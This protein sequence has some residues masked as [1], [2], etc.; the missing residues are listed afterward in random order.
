MKRSF[1]LYLFILAVLINVFTYAFFTR[2]HEAYEKE[3]TAKFKKANDSIIVLYNK[4]VDAEYFSI[5]G[6]QNAQDYLQ[7]DINQLVQVITNEVMSLNDDPKGNRLI[8]YDKINDQ[9][10][11]VNKV[12]V[13]NHRWIICD[14]SDGQVW[15]ELLLKYFVEADGKITFERIDAQLYKR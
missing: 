15:G 8:P 14:F 12:K 9:K 13:L 7:T 3:H 6:N 10:F 11:I 2:Q 5:E 4:L 1:F